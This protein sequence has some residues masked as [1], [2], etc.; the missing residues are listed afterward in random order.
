MTADKNYQLMPAVFYLHLAPRS[1]RMLKECSLAGITFLSR[2]LASVPAISNDTKTQLAQ[3]RMSSLR[4]GRGC[5]PISKSQR[6]PR[7]SRTLQQLVFGLQETV[8]GD[9]LAKSSCWRVLV[10]IHILALCYSRQMR[11]S[12]KGRSAEMIGKRQLDFAADHVLLQNLQNICVLARYPC[13]HG[14]FVS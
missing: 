3:I 2:V 10:V 5:F 6:F 8:F 11:V 14:V 13:L 1:E 12:A 9:L 7:H 4:P